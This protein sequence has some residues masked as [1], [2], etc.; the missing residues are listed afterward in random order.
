MNERLRKGLTGIA[1]RQE[2]ITYGE[3]AEFLRLSMDW[4]PDRDKMSEVL[5]EI[6]DYEHQNGRPLLSVVV[7]LA[8]TGEPGGGFFDLAKATGQMPTDGDRALFFLRELR[9][10]HDHWARKPKTAVTGK[11]G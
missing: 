5:G 2:T 11:P 6:S 4:P 3:V 7:V 1:R 10:V 9:R 8:A